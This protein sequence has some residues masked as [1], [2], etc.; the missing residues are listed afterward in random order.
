[1]QTPQIAANA[2]GLGQVDASIKENDVDSY[3]KIRIEDEKTS[4]AAQTNTFF[5]GILAT[6]KAK[7]GKNKANDNTFGDGGGVSVKTGKAISKFSLFTLFGSNVLG[8][9]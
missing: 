6:F 2:A 8:P 7:T 9:L 3:N 4:V 1:M 5:V